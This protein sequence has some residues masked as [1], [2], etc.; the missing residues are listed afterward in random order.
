MPPTHGHLEH[1]TVGIKID[2]VQSTR[3]T[4]TVSRVPIAQLALAIM[5]PTSNLASG[6]YHTNKIIVYII[7]TTYDKSTSRITAEI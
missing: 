5:T 3:H 4:H 2:V 6:K 7:L 1:S